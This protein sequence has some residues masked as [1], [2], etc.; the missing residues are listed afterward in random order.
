VL[1]IEADRRGFVPAVFTEIRVN[2]VVTGEIEESVV[3]RA[4]KLSA[5]GVLLCISLMLKRWVLNCP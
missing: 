1:S 3:A 5:E 4:V 2:F